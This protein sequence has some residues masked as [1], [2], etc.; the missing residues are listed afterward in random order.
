MLVFNA[1]CANSDEYFCI[2]LLFVDI[3]AKNRQ[4]R[5]HDG[6]GDE[7]DVVAQD[8]KLQAMIGARVDAKKATEY[9]VYEKPAL[10]PRTCLRR[11]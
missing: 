7:L 4:A 1:L 10:G 2:P 6:N 11:G 9:K 3:H 5:A 8:N